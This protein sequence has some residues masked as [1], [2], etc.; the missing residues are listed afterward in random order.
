MPCRPAPCSRHQPAPHCQPHDRCDIHA[1]KQLQSF[2]RHS[3]TPTNS[4]PP[5]LPAG[6]QGRPQVGPG[7]RRSQ[8]A[9]SLQAR[10]RRPA[11][12]QKI[13]EEHRQG[14]RS[15][16]DLYLK[17]S[18][19]AK[20]A[21]VKYALADALAA[22]FEASCNSQSP[23]LCLNLKCEAISFLSANL[24]LLPCRAPDSQAALPA[25]GA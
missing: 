11:R 5:V 18:A 2:L 6:H 14:F 12:D 22:A 23:V 20:E 21:T 1:C 13:S 19:H 16:R 24:L 10:N 8:E 25:P 4:S 17:Q 7:H 15:A 3:Y 9:S